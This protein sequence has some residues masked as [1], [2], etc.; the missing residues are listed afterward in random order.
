MGEPIRE[1]RPPP[2]QMV[3]LFQ[4]FHGLDFL[5]RP[6]IPHAEQVARMCDSLRMVERS[7]AIPAFKPRNRQSESIIC[8]PF[9]EEFQ[10]VVLTFL[11]GPSV[12]VRNQIWYTGQTFLEGLVGW[13]NDTLAYAWRFA[14]VGSADEKSAWMVSALIDGNDLFNFLIPRLDRLGTFR[15]KSFVP[16]DLHELEYTIL[17]GVP[18]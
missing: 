15:V 13:A 1:P 16:L 12:G 5:I 4:R 2:T 7:A 11:K 18:N 10:Y 6:I 8:R 3:H 14:D 17:A 9:R